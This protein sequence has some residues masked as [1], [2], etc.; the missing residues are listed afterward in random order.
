MRS[1]DRAE[2]WWAGAWPA[3][4]AVP[5]V[6]LAAVLLATVLLSRL[7]RWVWTASKSKVSHG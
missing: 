2:G 6:T 4:L 7:P 3:T 5:A 1:V